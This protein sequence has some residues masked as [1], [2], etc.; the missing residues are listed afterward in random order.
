MK[1]NILGFTNENPRWTPLAI[2]CY[3]RGCV[4]ENCFYKNI[5]N[6]N[7]QMK[8]TVLELVR[9]LGIPQVGNSK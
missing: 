2:E 7:C 8:A 9:I 6:N 1:R 5:L 3:E 4:C